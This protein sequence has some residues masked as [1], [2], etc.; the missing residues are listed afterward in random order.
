MDILSQERDLLARL[1]GNTIEWNA[2]LRMREHELDGSFYVH[3]FL[4]DVPDSQENWMDAP[5]LVGTHFVYTSSTGEHEGAGVQVEGFVCLQKALKKMAG[6]ENL[7][8]SAVVP[9]LKKNLRWRVVT[10]VSS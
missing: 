9:Y 3:L 2:R 4:G 5:N 8:S 1:G 7:E 6:L 10:V